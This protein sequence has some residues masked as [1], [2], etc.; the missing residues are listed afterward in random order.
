MGKMDGLL[1]VVFLMVNISMC[2]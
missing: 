1:K 2:I